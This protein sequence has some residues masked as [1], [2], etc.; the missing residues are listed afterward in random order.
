MV[1][2]AVGLPCLACVG[3]LNGPNDAEAPFAVTAF[4][5]LEPVIQVPA[6]TL[7]LV[8]SPDG[9]ELDFVSNR[10]LARFDVSG[11]AALTPIDWTW[12]ENGADRLVVEGD[13]RVWPT[14]SGAQLARWTGAGWE[15]LPP[16]TIPARLVGFSDDYALI[17]FDRTVSLVDRETYLAGGATPE[18]VVATFAPPLAAFVAGE[19]A[20]RDGVVWIGVDDGVFA[21]EVDDPSTPILH[22]GDWMGDVVRVYG[23]T[24]VM[25]AGYDLLFYDISDA[26]HPVPLTHV[27][28]GGNDFVVHGDYLYGVDRSSLTIVDL[29]DPSSPTPVGWVP[30][31]LECTSVAVNDAAVFVACNGRVIRLEPNTP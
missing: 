5:D 13:V 21:F 9:N 16:S 27:R 25:R 1:V 14:D 4:R 3:D 17:S 6:F 23:A 2:V 15:D 18:D 26:R 20:E 24:L 28:G 19:A 29:A 7:R 8:A 10:S 22:L 31:E 11:P 12:L 30:L